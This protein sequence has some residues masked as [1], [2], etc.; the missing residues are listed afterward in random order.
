MRRGAMVALLLCLLAPALGGCRRAATEPAGRVVIF[1]LDSPVDTDFI[2]G[3]EAGRPAS[4]IGHG[5]LVGRVIRHYCAADVISVPVEELDGSIS[6]DAYLRGLRH[7]LDYAAAHPQDRMIAN[8][9]LGSS[10]P[11]PEERDLIRRIIAAGVLVVAAA[12]NDDSE[13][14]DY[15]AGYPDV[16]AVANA[17]PAGKA[18]SSNYGPWIS[19]AASG[20]ITFIDYEWLPYERLQR[21][22]NARGTSFAA[23]RVA[24]AVAWAMAR[25]PS[26]SPQQA[27][28]IVRGA[29]DPIED[30]Y[31]YRGQ[32]GAGLLDFD[33]LRT[34]ATPGFRFLHYELPVIVWV[35]LGLVSAWLCWRRGLPGVFLSLILWL[36]A[37]PVTVLFIVGFGP[38]GMALLGLALAVAAA[39]WLEE[40]R[41][42]AAARQGAAPVKGGAKRLLRAYR[43]S[44][45]PRVRAAAVVALGRV[46]DAEAVRFLLDEKAYPHSAVQ[47]LAEQARR[48]PSVLREPL[49]GYD[50][51]TERQQKRLAEAVLKAAD[52]RI[53]ALVEEVLRQHPSPDVERL[54]ASVRAATSAPD[55]Q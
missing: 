13:R 15:P 45:N 8:I 25:R 34:L 7:V 46:P 11:D 14:P 29:A 53:M 16:V 17:G 37:L 54:I 6:R 9:S 22:M 31:F 38:T 24:A 4:T 44:F 35:L 41:M 48:D 33:R 3:R 36:V 39:V 32:L 12:G 21:E 42:L 5:S 40:R 20:D 1:V 18:P 23:P 43:W 19:I 2:E 55:A 51:L 27:Y 30:A 28:A 10:R 47:A 49:E 52:P 26:L 50:G